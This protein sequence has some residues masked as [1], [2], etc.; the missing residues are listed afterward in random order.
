MRLY[1]GISK[2]KLEVTDLDGGPERLL[3]AFGKLDR[4]R[5][6]EFLRDTIKRGWDG[7]VMTSSSMNHAEEYGWPDDDPEDFVRSCIREVGRT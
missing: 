5:F 6:V 4:A 2:G 7:H 3:G 1:F